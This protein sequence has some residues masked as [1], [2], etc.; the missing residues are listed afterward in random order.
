MIGM[1]RSS[2][3]IFVSALILGTLAGCERGTSVSTTPFT[4]HATFA[5]ASGKVRTST[6]E[7]ADTGAERERGLMNRNTLAPNAGMVFVFD[8][9]TTNSFWMKDTPIPLSIAFWGDG[10]R[11]V[12]ILDMQ[13]CT[14]DPCTVYTPRG[15]YTR[16]LEMNLGWFERR[17]VQI[18]DRVEL[19]LT[20]E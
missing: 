6:L 11:V 15:P 14:T 20:P 3:V 4:G 5:T 10:G 7:I 12:D 2:P 1:R 18:G 8:G 17:G 9:E 16:A 13:P 19:Q